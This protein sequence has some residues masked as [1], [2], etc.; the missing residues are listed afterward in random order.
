M[1]ASFKA[2]LLEGVGV[3]FIVIAVGSAQGRVVYAA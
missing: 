3:V 2:V 1:T